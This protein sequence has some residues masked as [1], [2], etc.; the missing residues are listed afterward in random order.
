MTEKLKTITFPPGMLEQIKFMCESEELGMS[1]INTDTFAVLVIGRKE[2]SPN[3]VHLIAAHTLIGGIITGYWEEANDETAE[4][5]DKDK[6]RK[7]F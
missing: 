1:A 7:P 6:E 4:I 5:E 3:F 2:L